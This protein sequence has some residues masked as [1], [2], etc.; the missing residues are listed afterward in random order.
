MFSWPA[1][2]QSPY[3]PYHLTL[4][5]CLSPW[6]RESDKKIGLGQDKPSKSL[7]SASRWGS[8]EFFLTEQSICSLKA[9]MGQGPFNKAG[10]VLC[11]SGFQFGPRQ[12]AGKWD[13]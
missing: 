8:V 11:A 6:L 9:E 12:V 5:H 4:F 13:L 10:S 1:T 7:P 3:W 2:T